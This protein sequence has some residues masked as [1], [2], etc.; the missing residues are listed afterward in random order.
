MASSTFPMSI[1]EILVSMI[2]SIF[3]DFFFYLHSDLKLIVSKLDMT[4]SNR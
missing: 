4:S 3:D 1:Q 2:L